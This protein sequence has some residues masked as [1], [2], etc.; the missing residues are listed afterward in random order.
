[1]SFL[2]LRAEKLLASLTTSYYRRALFRGVFPTIE[3][4]PALKGRGL[5]VLLI[6]VQK[7]V[8]SLRSREIVFLNAELSVSNR[9]IGR[10]EF[11]ARS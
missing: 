6:L 8:S 5:T 3:H 10:P 1:M 9:S 7:G 2:A 4:G 11:I